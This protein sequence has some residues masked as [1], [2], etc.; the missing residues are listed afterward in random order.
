[1]RLV[2]RPTP[3]SGEVVKV[4]VVLS[5]QDRLTVEAVTR[6]ALEEGG[7]IAP[8]LAIH[9]KGIARAK[10]RLRR[11]DAERVALLRTIAMRTACIEDLT[12]P[13]DSG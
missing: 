5:E 12:E 10:E 9:E 6:R 1:M 13:R 11:L 4:A 8:L 3:R 2:R 7:D